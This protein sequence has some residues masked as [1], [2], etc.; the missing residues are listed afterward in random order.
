MTGLHG[1]HETVFRFL[2]M[3]QCNIA[4]LVLMGPVVWYFPP[5]SK[6]ISAFQDPNTDKRKTQNMG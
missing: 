6:C 3:I 2:V 4:I 5:E 1:V